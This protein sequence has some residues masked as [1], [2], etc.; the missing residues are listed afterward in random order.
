MKG[1][2]G[3]RRVVPLLASGLR[4]WDQ[5]TQTDHSGGLRSLHRISVGNRGPWLCSEGVIKSREL[6]IVLE[7]LHVVEAGSGAGEARVLK[8]E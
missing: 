2:H 8:G 3:P 6:L 7:T 5:R 4:F 1:P